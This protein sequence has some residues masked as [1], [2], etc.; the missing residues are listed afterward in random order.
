MAEAGEVFWLDFPGAVKTKRRPAVVVSS[1]EYHRKRP[2]AILGLVTSQ[3]SKAT[4]PTD[5]V[6]NDW[7]IAGMKVPSAFRTFLVTVPQAVLTAR[8]GRLSDADWQAVQEC[9]RRAL[10]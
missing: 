2:D 8:L 10:G 5:H 4:T 7:T 1:H 9:V 3:I 6:L